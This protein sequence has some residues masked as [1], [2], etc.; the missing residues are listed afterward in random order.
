MHAILN[1]SP[2]ESPAS[3]LLFLQHDLTFEV[4]GNFVNLYSIN[5]INHVSLP[6]VNTLFILSQSLFALRTEFTLLFQAATAWY[7]STSRG[8]APKR[9]RD[10]EER[11]RHQGRA[12]FLLKMS[13]FSDVLV[14]VSE[15]QTNS[16][17]LFS[18]SLE[19]A[20]QACMCKCAALLLCTSQRFCVK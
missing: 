7:E 6:T 3:T 13:G 1:S 17:T 5:R 16:D 4:H 19:I 15:L 10:P 20:R 2:Q 18:T 8:K 11:P 12:D 9:G 14:C